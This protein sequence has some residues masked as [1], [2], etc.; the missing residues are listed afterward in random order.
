MNGSRNS[1]QQFFAAAFASVAAVW[2]AASPAH[3]QGVVQQ[4]TLERDIDP[5]AAGALDP[6]AAGLPRALWRGTPRQDAISLTEST[7]AR[8]VSPTMRD[9]AVRTVA[10]AAEPPAGIQQSPG[11]AEARAAALIR[12]G[13]A[14]LAADLLGAVPRNKRSEATDRMLLDAALLADNRFNACRVARDRAGQAEDIEFAK[15]AAFCEALSGD[16]TRADFQAALI[17]ERAPDDAAFFELL[18]LVTGAVLKPGR[19]VKRVKSPSPLEMA[20]LRAAGLPPG[21]LP[22]DA[23][24]P[25]A[26]A[27]E[28]AISTDPAAPLDQR[29]VAAW[30]TLQA[31]TAD[32]PATR[33]L[34]FATAQNP[35]KGPSGRI[36]KALT[37]AA[38]SPAGPDRALALAQLLALG[39]E[40]DAGPATAQLARPLLADL[41]PLASGPDI[42]LRIAHGLLLAD[43]IQQARR[44][45]ASLARAGAVPGATAAAARLQ[46]VLA[47]ADGT[48]VTPFN[49]PAFALWHSAVGNAP[50]KAA[51]LGMLR[52]AVGL[53]VGP[54]Q[55]QA[56]QGWTPENPISASELGELQGLASAGQIGAV[57]LR[58]AAM[59]E[60][61][62]TG[63][64]PL[65]LAAV[66]RALG[67]VGLQAEARRVAVEAAVAGGL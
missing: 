17:A 13:R 48:D 11:F 3:G 14:D 34:F 27:R 37:H 55:L 12:M 2:L 16:V 50:G 15:A 64:R 66:A 46:A 44:W 61:S 33:Q 21:D 65:R 32:L 67:A 41:L 54:Q 63:A 49:A 60:T 42:G 57:V 40:L 36:A 39:D 52:Q 58:G 45:R 7:P 31:N 6:A 10:V 19:A 30:R 47:L 22:K 20:M 5:A 23:D 18:G 29:S 56:A 4:L 38:A 62:E 9:L 28:R 43:E 8:F 53:P 26:L 59:A 24:A 35:G 51:L 1:L 25:N